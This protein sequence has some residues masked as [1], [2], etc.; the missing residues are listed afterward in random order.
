MNEAAIHRAI[1]ES[2]GAATAETEA[3]RQAAL[4]GSRLAA[5]F[6]ALEVDY[7]SLH[8]SLYLQEGLNAEH[9]ERPRD[10]V[11]SRSDASRVAIVL[12]KDFRPPRGKAGTL[13]AELSRDPNPH[14]SGPGYYTSVYLVRHGAVPEFVKSEM[15]GAAVVT[16]NTS[17]PTRKAMKAV[18]PGAVL[19]PTEYTPELLEE[20]EAQL[21]EVL[22]EAKATFDLLLS[23]ACDPE[24]NPGLA[25]AA[26]A[27]RAD[28]LGA[29]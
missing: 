7:R 17:P 23:S 12:A 10:M 2:A 24:L 25:E 5:R 22:P 8:T 20:L 16:A 27:Y 18:Q 26:Q 21:D 14:A 15:F 1:R 3:E 4:R 19:L 9:E 13:V 6:E 29:D 11:G 28:L